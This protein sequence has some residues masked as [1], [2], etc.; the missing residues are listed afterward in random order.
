MSNTIVVSNVSALIEQQ[1]I[2]DLFSTLGPVVS[3]TLSGP[4]EARVATVTFTVLWLME[5]DLL[6][7]LQV[8]SSLF[9]SGCCICS[10]RIDA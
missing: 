10:I 4:S 1:N 5:F 7:F 8:I 6:N 3:C 9:D 2:H